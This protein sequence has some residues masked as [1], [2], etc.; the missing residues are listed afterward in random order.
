MNKL[1]SNHF[2]VFAI[3]LT[4][5][6]TLFSSPCLLKPSSLYLKLRYDKSGIPVLM[7]HSIKT[8]KGNTLCVSEKQF[9]MEMHWLYSQGYHTLNIEEFSS[10]LYNT[11]T[12]PPKSILI[13]FDDGYIDNYN[14]ASSILRRYGFK[15]TFFIITDFVKKPDRINWIQLKEL[16][17]LG[18][19]IGSH[20]VRHLDLSTLSLKQQEYELGISKQVLEKNLG[21]NITAFCFP[22][23]RYNETTLALLPKLGYK[24]GFTTQQ[25]FV[26]PH[27][28]KFMLKRVRIY[29][30]MPYTVFQKLFT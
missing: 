7:Y 23:G 27:D 16:I 4:L 24:L 21:I 25:G 9:D 29:G 1:K 14:I 19:S 28:N 26:H 3:I 17:N 30:G 20:S 18:N 10:A 8:I 15:A 5:T 13:T 2:F 22:S 12:L 6:I 11:V